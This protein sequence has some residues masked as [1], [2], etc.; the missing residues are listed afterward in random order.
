MSTPLAAAGLA[1]HWVPYSIIKVA[2]RLPS[3]VGMRATV[4]LGGCFL[5]FTLTYVG[6][7]VRVGLRRGLRAG[8]GAFVAAPACGYVALL[9]SERLA[10]IGGVRRG[11]E[12]LRHH[13]VSV[14]A[15]RAQRAEVVADALRLLAAEHLDP[16]EQL[17]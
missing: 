2:G 6:I 10:R 15:L 8:V 11:I 17:G 1:V 7:G 13:Q 9:W 14:S 3:N 4:K 12:A 16:A 5:L